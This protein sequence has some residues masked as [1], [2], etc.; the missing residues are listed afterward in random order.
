MRN[1]N[2]HVVD[3]GVL[4]DL[5]VVDVPHR[6]VV[7]DLRCQHYRT[8]HDASPVRR[9][10]VDF[11]VV[12]KTLDVHKRDYGAFCRELSRREQR[13]NEPVDL[14]MVRV[15][16]V[17]LDRDGITLQN[18]MIWN[19]RYGMIFCTEMGCSLSSNISMSRSWYRFLRFAMW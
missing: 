16:R 2:A 17:V 5:A 18:A 13:S 19:A 9:T 15:T 11:R 12:E 4:Q 8:E 14:A 7:P 6:L 3:V 1:K 10:Q